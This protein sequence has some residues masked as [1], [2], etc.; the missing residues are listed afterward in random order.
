MMAAPASLP[1]GL[2]LRPAGHADA[3]AIRRLVWQVH[4]NPMSLDWRR[5]TLVVDADGR[6]LACAQVKPHGDGT[7]ELASLAVQP[8]WRGQGL[9]GVL[10]A[11]FQR[12]AGPP[13]YLTCRIALEP[14]YRRFGF[15]PLEDAEL[16]PYFARLQRVANLFGWLARRRLES[17]MRWDVPLPPTILP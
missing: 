11:H 9:A 8:G 13:L 16:T 4:I 15:R 6:M 1:A 10:I 7:R 2:R 3:A 17:I 14:F 12:Q 5:F